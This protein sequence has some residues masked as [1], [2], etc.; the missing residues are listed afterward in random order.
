MASI[1]YLLASNYGGRKKL[2][3]VDDMNYSLISFKKGL[4][5]YYEIYLAD[6]YIQMYKILEN[7]KPEVIL[8]DINI[9]EKNGYEIIKELK[10]D[11]RYCEIPV[12]FL[13]SSIDRASVVKGLALGA[14]DYVVKP[15][16]AK[17]IIESIENQFN[18]QN[19]KKGKAAQ[20]DVNTPNILVVDDIPSMLRTI[21]FAL[22]D[23][24]N[25]SLLSKPEVV[26]DFLQSNKPDLILLDY[27]MPGLSG[28]DLIPMIKALPD[29][30]DV[31][32][33]IVTTEGTFKNVS[34]ALSHGAS[35]FIVKPFDPNELNYKIERQIRL[36][37]E[38]KEKAEELT[39]FY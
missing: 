10:I 22:S 1:D 15:F 31:P 36:S 13:T 32:I 29:H 30:K 35:D 25:V 20:K 23:R 6:S 27:L 18:P 11:E 8:L 17:K 28:F 34:D 16:D 24:Y 26:I 14:A 38:L 33:I 4:E 19:S 5:K 12:I 39:G 9:P 21:H 7:V 3:Y 37:R 2:L